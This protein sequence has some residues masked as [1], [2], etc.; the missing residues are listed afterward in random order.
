MPRY[1]TAITLGSRCQCRVPGARAIPASSLRESEPVSQ[2]FQLGRVEIRTTRLDLDVVRVWF[3]PL[4]LSLLFALTQ[5]MS[6]SAQIAVDEPLAKPKSVRV[7]VAVLPFRVFASDPSD[8]LEKMVTRLLVSRLEASGGVEVVEALTVREFLIARGNETTEE[9]LQGLA[10]ELGAD[11]VVAGSL[12]EL[13]GRFSIDVRITSVSTAVASDALALTA[14]DEND[15]LDRLTEVAE[16]ILESIGVAKPQELVSAIRFEGVP[17][18]PGMRDMVPLARGDIYDR[19]LA[20]EAALALDTLDGTASVSFRAER[21][22]EGVIVV[23]RV[24]PETALP[25]SIEVPD[26]DLADRIVD[27]RVT[28]NGRIEAKAILARLETQPGKAFQS[29]G[30]S[31]D[32][33]SI[34]ELGFFRDVEVTS[35]ETSDG[36][37]ITF[38]LDEHPL[39]RQ[40]SVAGNEQIE[41]DEI[42]DALT[43]TTGASL[44]LPTVI[45]NRDRILGLYRS[46][47]HY[48]A[49]VE[50][51]IETLDDGTVGVQYDVIEG[52]ELKLRE[53]LIEGNEHFEDPELL[54]GLETRAWT[55]H[56]LATQYIDDAGTY[57]EPVFMQDVQ[58][59]TDLYQNAGFL[60]VEISEPDVVPGEEGITVSIE[61]EEGDRYTV[62]PVDVEGDDSMDIEA[63][64]EIV[65]IKEGE[66]FNRGLLTS[67]S[68]RLEAHYTNRGFYF[69]KVEPKTTI[70]ED[71]H[72]VDVA[73][74]VEKGPLYFI[75]KINVSGNTITHDEIIRRE[76]AVVEHQL[77]SARSVS[78]SRSRVRGLGF[79]E[80]V[81]FEPRATDEF[82]QLDL[83]IRVV[84]Q[85]TGSISFGAGFSS[86]DSFLINGS[87]SQSNLFG[88]GYSASLTA[89]MGGRTDRLMGSFSDPYFLGST[90]GANI[91][92]NTFSFEYDDFE[93]ES[94]GFELSLSHPLSFSKRA[95]GF[96]TYSYQN[97][98]IDLDNKFQAPSVMLREIYTGSQ[99]TSML[100]LAY[101]SDNRNDRV[102]AT[103]GR[104]LRSSFEY[105]GLGGFSKFIRTQASATYFFRMPDWIP[106]WY[107]LKE[108]SS[109]NLGGA[110]GWLVPFNSVSDFDFEVTDV[111]SN[112]DDQVEP[113]SQIDK[114]LKVPLSERYFLGG[115]GRRGLRGF[116]NRSVGPRRTKIVPYGSLYMPVGYNPLN[117]A[118]A[119]KNTL[120]VGGNRDGKCNNL[121]NKDIDDFEDLDET[122]VIGGN[123]FFTVKSEYRFPISEALGLIGIAFLD[124][125]N[126]FDEEQNIWD[127]DEWRFGT[128][129]GG[130]WYSPFG[131][132]EAYLGLPLDKLEDEEDGTV[133]EFSMGGA[134]F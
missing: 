89:D 68:E 115:I 128:G 3:V 45:E 44:D 46:T 97:R 112:P 35:E 102:S 75:R 61:I 20:R 24:V 124:M 121:K 108:R 90:F 10:R 71:S 40:V 70:D 132:V 27:V 39:I 53:I 123:K 9:G 96:L 120:G 129:F 87:V 18:Q 106:N 43:L 122:E 33:R 54:L 134:Q 76:V 77:Y 103:S 95:H 81:S 19:N 6:A 98:D 91:R 99:S 117:G 93:Q 59:I 60:R 21:D 36:R 55:W 8:E 30:I 58:N 113:L 111:D 94:K 48:L 47:G 12:T 4:V 14:D 31:A 51:T 56:S 25:G 85:P 23:F 125:G 109:F 133:F 1:V 17:E 100:G 37:I 84:E 131:P 16:L 73:F 69:A 114:D 107:P 32:V 11:Y 74:S 79:F 15:L 41:S 57:A 50:F 2:S 119:V 49:E 67:D 26:V 101:V 118:C 78:V 92:V 104:V 66:F 38:M 22:N 86:Q 82:N 64:R 63:L 7:L 52:S 105:A 127:F 80:E 13:A 83:S 116:R 65:G 62:G 42:R 130:L 126:A 5:A 110:F 72:V 88:R 34:F 29:S 28:G